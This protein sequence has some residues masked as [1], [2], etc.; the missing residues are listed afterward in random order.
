MTLYCNCLPKSRR[1]SGLATK[2]LIFF[3]IHLAPNSMIGPTIASGV[4]LNPNILGENIGPNFKWTI[5]SYT[6]LFNKLFGENSACKI[7]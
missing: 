6:I 3:T 7:S 5:L 4:L 1:S 2:G